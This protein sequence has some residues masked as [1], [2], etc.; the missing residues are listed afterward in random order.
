MKHRTLLLFVISLS[1]LVS[2]AS[3]QTPQPTQTT[4]VSA[5]AVPESCPVTKPPAHPFVPP[6]PYPT[7]TG[8]F[9]FGTDKLWTHLP[10]N[11]TWRLG[12]PSPSDT[13]FS[14]KLFWWRKGFG[15]G[16]WE[17]MLTVTG[18]RLDSSAPPFA[19]DH[20]AYASWTGDPNHPFIVTGID[21]PT[22]GCWQI[23]GHFKD[24]ELSFVIWVTQ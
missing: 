23:T 7:E 20:H 5:D 16:D 6:S 12:H 18:R 8:G 24:A 2:T 13:T 4:S 22:L 11:G 14:Q 1:S 3:A 19:I 9:W 21:I 17:T 15:R 10:K